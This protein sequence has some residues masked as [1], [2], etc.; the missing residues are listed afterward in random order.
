M[1]K[2]YPKDQ[3]RTM[4]LYLYSWNF[5]LT[6][7]KGGGGGVFD[8]LSPCILKVAYGDISSYDPNGSVDAE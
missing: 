3:T 2:I 8:T 6:D 5:L 7:G 4:G 1:K